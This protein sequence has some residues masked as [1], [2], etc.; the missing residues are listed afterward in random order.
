MRFDKSHIKSGIVG[1][2]IGAGSVW[3]INALLGLSNS[4]VSSFIN[5]S[6][7]RGKAS[8]YERVETDADGEV[9]ITTKGKK[10]HREDCYILRQ[11]DEVKRSSRSDVIS[12]GY[13]PCKKC[14]P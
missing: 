5:T 8:M 14:R 10:Y 13:E 4:T 1:A 11:S 12:V 2:M 9:F 3:G 7:Y 6:S